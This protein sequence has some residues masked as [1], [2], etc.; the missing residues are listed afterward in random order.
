MHSALTSNGYRKSIKAVRRQRNLGLVHSEHIFDST[1]APVLDRPYSNSTV[2]FSN[3]RRSFESS[4]ISHKEMTSVQIMW[5]QKLS[6][7]TTSVQSQR[8][9]F[10]KLPGHTGFKERTFAS[11]IKKKQTK[12]YRQTI[13]KQRNLLW[14]YIRFYTIFVLLSLSDLCQITGSGFADSL[15]KNWKPSNISIIAFQLLLFS[16][17]IF[18]LTQCYLF[19]AC[20]ATVRKVLLFA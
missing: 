4:Y 11:F 3:I 20:K 13:T 8:R 2:H 17:Q 19:L 14:I 7:F 1:Q 15:S 18:I 10:V 12:K 6:I 5:F 9:K 16:G